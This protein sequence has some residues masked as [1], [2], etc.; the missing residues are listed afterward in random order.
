MP[1]IRYRRTDDERQAPQRTW[2]KKF[3][4]LPDQAMI[5]GAVGIGL[6]GLVCWIVQVGGPGETIELE[7]V[8]ERHASYQIDMNLADSTQWAELPGIGKGLAS[9]ILES[10]KVDGPFTSHDDLMRV[11]GIG[12]KKM[13]Q[14]RPYLLAVPRKP[15][16]RNM[17]GE[18]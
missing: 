15:G 11:K 5:A 8:S 6:I 17:G 16:T 10:R 2:R 12:P 18:P 3:V 4:H 1:D 14:I 7:R 13:E 9:R